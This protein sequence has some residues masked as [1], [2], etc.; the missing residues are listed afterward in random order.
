MADR[1]RPD[2]LRAALK[3]L[4]DYLDDLAR[5][6]FDEHATKLRLFV[7]Y[8]QRDDTVR[9]LAERLH[10]RLRDVLRQ[11][12]APK[13]ELPTDPLD[14]LAFIYEVLFHLK[15][16]DRLDVR[17]FL[18]RGF[19]GGSIEAKWDDFRNRWLAALVE[20]FRDLNERIESILDEDPVDPELIFH[21]AMHSGVDDAFGDPEPDVSVPYA[22]PTEP[23][24][25]PVRPEPSSPRKALDLLRVS[26]AREPASRREDLESELQVLELELA[27]KAPDRERLD[28]IVG[29]FAAASPGIGDLARAATS[30]VG[31]KPV[32]VKKLVRKPVPAKKKPMPAA[33]KPVA[34]AKVKAGKAK[35]KAKPAA[36]PKAKKGKRG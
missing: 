1:V 19:E 31:G 30:H 12:L 18:S 25:E 2:A 34:S 7:N 5:S 21:I 13:L 33:R 4:R 9:Y 11:V 6:S 20:G 32:K 22:P 10:M 17:E 23:E 36:R 14:R 28:E 16:G 27:K 26:V 3:T 35:A 24:L 8:F 29:V 15:S